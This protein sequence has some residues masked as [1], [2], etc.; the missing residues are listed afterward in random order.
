MFTAEDTTVSEAEQQI[1]TFV[2]EGF[3]ESGAEEIDVEPDYGS[4]IFKRPGALKKL[5]GKAKK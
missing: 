2:T 5:L 3:N 1:E 4:S